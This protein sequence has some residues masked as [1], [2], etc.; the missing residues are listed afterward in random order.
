MRLPDVIRAT[1]SEIHL[2]NWNEGHI[3]PSQ[4]PVKA[5]A[6]SFKLGRGWAW[7]V[8]RFLAG[9]QPY[10]VLVLF[11]EG[12]QIYR[13]VLGRDDGGETRM[14]CIHEFHVTEPGWHCHF[15][16]DGDEPPI[17][18]SRFGMRRRPRGAKVSET[19]D[20]TKSNAVQIALKFYAI[21]ERGTLL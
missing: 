20:V 1:K 14:I 4:F 7:C 19:F 10:R 8:I 13:A 12:K 15:V 21:S 3:P 17:G 16:A 6:R 9:G 11:N 18:W 2:G 5:K